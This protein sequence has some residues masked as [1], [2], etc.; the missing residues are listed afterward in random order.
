MI[1][2]YL[3]DKELHLVFVDSKQT[4]CEIV[5]TQQLSFENLRNNQGVC[6]P[7]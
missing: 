6:E 3:F 2:Y 7:D 4:Y 5:L 1:E